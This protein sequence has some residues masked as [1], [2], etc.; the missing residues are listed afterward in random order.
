MAVNFVSSSVNAHQSVTLSQRFVQAGVALQEVA[1]KVAS[2]VRTFFC[3][4]ASAIASLFNKKT[5]DRNVAVI[6]TPQ[7]DVEPKA[8][9]EKETPATSTAI[10]LP[11]T[12]SLATKTQRIARTEST[13]FQGPVVINVDIT[14][15]LQ[16]AYLLNLA[17]SGARLSKIVEEEESS[18][19]IV[20]YVA[21]GQVDGTLDCDCNDAIT[22]ASDESFESD[23]EDEIEQVSG[24]TQSVGTLRSLARA[25]GYYSV[26]DEDDEDAVEATESAPS[27]KDNL[28]VS[29]AGMQESGLSAVHTTAETLRS[30]AATTMLFTALAMATVKDTKR[31]AARVLTPEFFLEAMAI[32]ANVQ[33]GVPAST[34]RKIR[35]VEQRAQKSSN[36]AAQA[37]TKRSF[38]AKP[39]KFAAMGQ[40][41]RGGKLNRR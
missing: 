21:P 16:M 19:A 18:L 29:L 4:V 2:A 11:S 31:K 17:N 5:L 12:T 28:M 24:R 26:V 32:A 39:P 20:P 6:S 9:A 38:T 22:V 10:I 35:K 33:V 7:S 34:V 8:S 27:F 37:A 1:S 41:M 15:L 14:A 40:Q 13:A 23:L 3:K 30:I 36:R 25:V